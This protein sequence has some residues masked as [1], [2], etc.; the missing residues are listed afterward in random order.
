V[1]SN[2]TRNTGVNIK[3]KSGLEVY[4]RF[5]KCESTVNKFML[6]RRMF[7]CVVVFRSCERDWNL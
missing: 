5:I 7:D 2:K 1:K 4:Q 6:H 3:K